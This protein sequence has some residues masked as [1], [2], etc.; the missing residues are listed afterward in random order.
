MGSLDIHALSES[1]QF[2]ILLLVQTAQL[3]STFLLYKSQPHKKPL[4]DG[5]KLPH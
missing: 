5:P 2:I 4:D 1:H 3:F